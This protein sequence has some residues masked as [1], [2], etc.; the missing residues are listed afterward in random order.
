MPL[1]AVGA[2]RLEFVSLDGD[3]GLR[4]VYANQAAQGHQ[5]QRE[6]V[7]ELGWP[8]DRQLNALPFR[9]GRLSS[10][11]HPSTAHIERLTRPYLLYRFLSSEHFITHVSL[12]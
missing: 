11:Q 7:V 4:L 8:T 3:S 9:Q 5:F 6:Y 1:Q 12:D 10:E 2:A